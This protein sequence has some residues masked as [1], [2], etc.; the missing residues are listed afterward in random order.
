VRETVTVTAELTGVPVRTIR[1]WIGQGRVTA[2]WDRGRLLVSPL[3]VSELA[4]TRGD[5]RL[6][7]LHKDA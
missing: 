4:E 2:T 5:G 3:E 6:R 7:R 1:N